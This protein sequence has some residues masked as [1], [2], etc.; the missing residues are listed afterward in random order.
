VLGPQDWSIIANPSAIKRFIKKCLPIVALE[1][2]H[3]MILEND[4]YLQFFQLW[5]HVKLKYVKAH[6]CVIAF[7]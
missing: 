6:T 5:A 1:W 3:T 2:G 4:K 7:S